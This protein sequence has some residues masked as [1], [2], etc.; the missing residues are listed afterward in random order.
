[1]VEP[2]SHGWASAID[3][4]FCPERIAEGNAMEELRALPQI[5]SASRTERGAPAGDRRCSGRLTA[6]SSR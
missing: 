3:V 5:V 2:C 6:Q 1:M 4:A